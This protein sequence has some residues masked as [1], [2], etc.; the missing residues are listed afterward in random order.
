[1]GIMA[2]IMVGLVVGLLAEKIVDSG[3]S[4]GRIAT[5]VLADAGSVGRGARP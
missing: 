3:D 5:T 4:H 2:L 1:M